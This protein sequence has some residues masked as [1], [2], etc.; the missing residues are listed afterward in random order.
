MALSFPL[1]S[2]VI[3]S[4]S[5][6][7]LQRS[8]RN[9]KRHIR[10]LWLTIFFKI[11]LLSVVE[12]TLVKT[13]GLLGLSALRSL[14]PQ[15]HR[16]TLFSLSPAELPGSLGPPEFCAHGAVCLCEWCSEDHAGAYCTH[17]SAHNMLHYPSDFIYKTQVQ[18]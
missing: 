4:I 16:L 12:R 8:N 1:L 15:C 5:C 6:W 9:N 13:D 17:L 7:Q 18:R 3:C 10:A 2:V 14:S 11:P